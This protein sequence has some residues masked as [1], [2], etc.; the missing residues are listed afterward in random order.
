MVQVLRYLGLSR[1]L[2]PNNVFTKFELIRILDDTVFTACFQL[3]TPLKEAAF[4]V[5]WP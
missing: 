1:M 5:V 2:K 4:D 3:F